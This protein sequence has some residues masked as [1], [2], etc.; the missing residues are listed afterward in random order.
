MININFIKKLK[1]IIFLATVYLSVSCASLS[2]NS[3]REYTWEEITQR[4]NCCNSCSFKPVL[5]LTDRDSLLIYTTIKKT[6]DPST[7][8]QLDSSLEEY[9]LTTNFDP[10][11]VSIYLERA[12]NHERPKNIY[13]NYER[14]LPILL[15]Y[16]EIELDNSLPLY[17][18]SYY[19][20]L[21]AD[22]SLSF[23]YLIEG[24]KR[25]KMDYIR[26]INNIIFNHVYDKTKNKCCSYAY[27]QIN[28]INPL[29]RNLSKILLDTDLSISHLEDIYEFGEKIE[30]ASLTVF[31]KGYGVFMQYDVAKKEKNEE[32]ATELLQKRDSYYELLWRSFDSKLTEQDYKLYLKNQHE[33]GEVY[34]L[35]NLLR[36]E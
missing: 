8:E 24:N 16:N 20:A 21:K 22:Y 14:I 13:T 2:L 12:L 9:L 32:L 26:E 27:S 1:V 17:Y 15:K 33:M 25:N 28:L 36:L 34:A 23:K 5:D 35:K 29:Y 3:V 31:G 6:G 7:E 11:I 30:D 19:Y 10:Y 4:V 18:L